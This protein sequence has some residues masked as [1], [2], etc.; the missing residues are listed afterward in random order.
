MKTNTIVLMVIFFAWILLLIFKFFGWINWWV[1][2]F[3][4]L[5]LALLFL[6]IW[7]SYEFYLWTKR[8]S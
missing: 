5:F 3:W 6:L 2:I 8:K 4:P 1:V 7:G